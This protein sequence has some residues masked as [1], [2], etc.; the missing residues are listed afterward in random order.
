MSVESRVLAAI[1]GSGDPLDVDVQKAMLRLDEECFTLFAHR[2]IF[3]FVRSL[4]KRNEL[5]DAIKLAD[6]VSSEHYSVFIELAALSSHTFTNCLEADID[7]LLN[8]SKRKKMDRLISGMVEEYKRETIPDVACNKAVERCIQLSRFALGDDKHT[9][10]SEQLAENLL[11]GKC[12]EEK[13]VP[14]GLSVLD[15][16]NNGGFKNKSLITIAGRPST[17]KSCFGVFL[18]EKLAANHDKKHVLFFSL[19]M[20][21]Q[22]VYQ[23]QI[24]SLAGKQFADLTKSELHRA[25]S[26]SLECPFTINEQQMASIGYIETFSR[27]TNAQRPVGVIVV[28][29]LSVVQNENK[30]ESNAL[31]VADITMRLAALAKELDCIVIALSQVNRDH[32]NRQD[33][34]PVPTDAADS[35]G[36]ERSSAYWIGIHRPALDDQHDQ[37]LKN[38]FVV[39]CRKNRWGEPWAAY[40]AFNKATFGEV[41]QHLLH[42]DSKQKNRQAKYKNENSINHIFGDI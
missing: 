33:K 7:H 22:E 36:S 11:S 35:S 3:I 17:G 6:V 41:D 38:Q 15:N 19:E 42:E 20:T 18:A 24:T 21:A 23:M 8:L 32:A 2:E 14:T 31:R 5:F 1:I 13:F 37:T 27:I 16:Q 34:C 28:D 26:K 39:K 29:Y 40:F 30:F 10:T 12:K 4:F 25:I 9:F